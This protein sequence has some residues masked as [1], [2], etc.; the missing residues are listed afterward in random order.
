MKNSNFYFTI[1]KKNLLVFNYTFKHS[2]KK[3]SSRVSDLQLAALYITSYIYIIHI[4]TL[5]LI[6]TFL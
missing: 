3:E 1:F 6:H 5:L 2:I 4:S